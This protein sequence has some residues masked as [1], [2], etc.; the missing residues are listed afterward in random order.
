[1]S[2][3]CLQMGGEDILDLDPMFWPPL[4]SLCAYDRADEGDVGGECGWSGRLSA[5]LEPRATLSLR[6]SFQSGPN[7]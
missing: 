7:E 6:L 2:L 3:L 4:C 5:L 1:M